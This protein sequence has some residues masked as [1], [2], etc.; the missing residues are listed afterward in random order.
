A[1]RILGMEPSSQITFLV[2]EIESHL[3]PKWQRQI[4]SSLL[5][6]LKGIQSDQ[7]W[8][9]AGKA[10]AIQLVVSTH[11]PVIMTALEDVFNSETDNW[12]DLDYAENKQNGAI[13]SERDF[14]R[15][16]VSDNWLTSEAFDL[17]SAR[18]PE[19][20]HEI[21][22]AK[23]LLEQVNASESDLRKS[24]Q[25]IASRLPATDPL[26]FRFQIILKARGIEVQ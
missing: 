17:D 13:V 7:E 3:H 26:I 5:V 18:S 9:P 24:F 6:A 8:M 25:Q 2:D 15:Q 16:G 14:I 21:N 4:I 19:A 10:T 1:C 11:S 20:E 23:Q 22:K 12:I